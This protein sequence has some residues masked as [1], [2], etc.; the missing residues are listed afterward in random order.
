[1]HRAR[2]IGL[3]PALRKSLTQFRRLTA[4]TARRPTPDRVH[5]LRVVTRRVRAILWLVPRSERSRG[6]RRARRDL[7]RLATILGEQRK[8]DVAL[9]DAERYNRPTRAIERKLSAARRKVIRA[10]RHKDRRRY[11]RH[12]ERALDDF[13]ALQEAGFAPR[14]AELAARLGAAMRQPP[15]TNAAR[16]RLR[17]NVKKARYLLEA[18]R[19]P[20][21]RLERLQDH[22]GRWH[23]LMV[24]STVTG[25]RVNVTAAC[26]RE[27]RLADRCLRPALHEAL[28][29]LS[30][31]TTPRDRERRASLQSLQ[32]RSGGPVRRTTTAAGRFP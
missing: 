18:A 20:A 21:A 1:M 14:I 31:L 11:A 8:Y 32:L 29:E 7:Q 2:S 10:V 23:D 27:R 12:L 17:I 5:D 19:R 15:K 4:Q 13:S 22:L 24:L 6:I 16:H 9:E 28:R 30:R 3:A 26:A 25:R